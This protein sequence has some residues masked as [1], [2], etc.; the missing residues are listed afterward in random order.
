MRVFEKGKGFL[1]SLFFNDYVKTFLP[2]LDA[3]YT[4]YDLI[5]LGNKIDHETDPK[6]KAVDATKMAVDVL[7]VLPLPGVGAAAN[8]VINAASYLTDVSTGK[9]DPPPLP[10]DVHT[11]DNPAGNIPNKIINSRPF[12][13]FLSNWG[14]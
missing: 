2:I 11:R 1:T 5:R 14:M 10:A 12:K 3:G 6:D 8:A 9:K 4:A 7:G 13:T